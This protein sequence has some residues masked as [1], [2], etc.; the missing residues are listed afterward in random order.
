M[1]VMVFLALGVVAGVMGGVSSAQNYCKYEAQTKKV[2]AQTQQVIA[3]SQAIYD[4]IQNV[5]EQ[6]LQENNNIQQQSLAASNSLLELRQAYVTE[7]KRDQIIALFIVVIVFMMLLGK[8]L[9]LY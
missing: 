2:L 7:L 9:K 8:K 4:N 6:V 1:A 3:N 5:D